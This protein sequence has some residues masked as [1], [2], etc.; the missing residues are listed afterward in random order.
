[1][2]SLIF[3]KKIKEKLWKKRTVAKKHQ[4]EIEDYLIIYIIILNQCGCENFFN[5]SIVFTHFLR[6]F[7]KILKKLKTY[8][9]C[10]TI[11]LMI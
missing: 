3:L 11:D 9:N 6:F 1:M 5:Y 4:Y 10:S 2:F 8:L 7:L